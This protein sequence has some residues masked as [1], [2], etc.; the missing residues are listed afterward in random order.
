ME[1][2]KLIDLSYLEQI[3]GGNKATVLKAIDLFVEQTP[4]HFENMNTYLH[5]EN[6]QEFFNE[7]HNVKS[8]L[9]MMGVKSLETAMEMVITTKINNQWLNRE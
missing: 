7:A 9:A 2:Y 4:K 1:R 3:C 8:S 5:E 6:W